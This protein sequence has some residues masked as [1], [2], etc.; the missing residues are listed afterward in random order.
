[1][2]FDFIRREMFLP[3]REEAFGFFHGDQ[4]H[5]LLPLGQE[6]IQ[7]LLEVD[8]ISRMSSTSNNSA[9]SGDARRTESCWCRLPAYRLKFIPLQ[10]SGFKEQPHEYRGKFVFD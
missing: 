4:L 1:V 10:R 2:Q 5:P 6:Q 7:R 9:R 3:A 8:L